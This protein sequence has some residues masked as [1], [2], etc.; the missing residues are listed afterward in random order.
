[1]KQCKGCGEVQ[2]AE[3]FN[4][5]RSAPDGRQTWCRTC[6]KERSKQFRKDNPEVARL[7]HASLALSKA[8]STIEEWVDLTPQE[9]S[10]LASLIARAQA[11]VRDEMDRLPR[12]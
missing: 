2:A 12:S 3:A 9:K 1:M 6:N 4:R 5:D 8:E 7:S 10:V 11:A